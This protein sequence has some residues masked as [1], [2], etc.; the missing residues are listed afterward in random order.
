[1]MMTP[2]SLENSPGGNRAN[3]GEMFYNISTKMLQTQARIM[4]TLPYLPCW[5]QSINSEVRHICANL[6]FI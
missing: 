1:M 5:Q 3:L 2:P 6:H 4:L